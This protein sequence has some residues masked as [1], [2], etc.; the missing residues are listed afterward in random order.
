MATDLNRKIDIIYSELMKKFDALSKHIKRVDGQVA[1][2]ATAIKREIGHLPWRTDTNPKC[3][4][5]VVLLRSRKRLIPSTVGTEIRTVDFRLN[6]ETR[7]TLIS[8][9]NRISAN[10]HTSSNQNMRITTIR[11][12]NKKRE[13][14]RSYSESAYERLQQGISLGSRAVSEI[15]SSSNPKTAKPN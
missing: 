2:N 11:I 3:Q 10:Y 12:R 15:P 7:K 1:E 4:A 9:R 14:S 6:K 8:Q 5:N 13:Q